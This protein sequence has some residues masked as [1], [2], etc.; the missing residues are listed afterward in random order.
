MGSGKAGDRTACAVAKSVLVWLGCG[1][2]EVE[3]KGVKVQRAGGIS[4]G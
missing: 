4:V 3:A 1:P 2:R